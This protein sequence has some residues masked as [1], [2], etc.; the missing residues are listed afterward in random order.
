VL[1]LALLA[2]CR[3]R[4]EDRA[5][6]VPPAANARVDICSAYPYEPKKTGAVVIQRDGAAGEVVEF[7]GASFNIHRDDCLA[8][9]GADLRQ[10]GWIA[11][12]G[13]LNV[14]LYLGDQVADRLEERCIHRMSQFEAMFVSGALYTIVLTHDVL[15]DRVALVGPDRDKQRALFVRLT[16]V[17][18]P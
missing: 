7:E 1:L 2:A 5:F 17:S 13:K 15:S 16:G 4:G 14:I 8:I 6:R 18:P 12:S 11:D 10:I 9:A 3:G